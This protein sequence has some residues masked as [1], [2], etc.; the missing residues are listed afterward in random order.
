[1]VF[2]K[3]VPG[4]GEPGHRQARRGSHGHQ[5]GSGSSSESESQ[6]LVTVTVNSGL[7]PEPGSE[8]TVGLRE[9]WWGGSRKP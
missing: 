5:R 7:K 9:G 6:A 8:R 4:E 1:M 3:A 2:G